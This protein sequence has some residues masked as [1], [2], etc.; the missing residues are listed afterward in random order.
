MTANIMV[1]E[2]E[3]AVQ[4]LIATNLL[5]AGHRVMR[6]DNAEEAQR[7]LLESLPDLAVV[8]WILPGQSGLSFLRGLRSKAPTRDM[9]LIMVTA[10]SS[11]HDKVTALESGADDYITKPFSPREMIARIYAVLRRRAPHAV[12][13]TL[14]LGKLRLDL[15]THRVTAGTRQVSLG[16]T[17]F[18]ML[19]FFMS[20]PGH[21]HSR[22]QLLDNIWG[23]SDLLEERTIDTYVGR[24]RSALKTAGCHGLIETLRGSGYRFLD[25]GSAGKR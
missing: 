10:R 15:V 25:P 14:E 19:R 7:M 5:L 17:E 9:P 3:P 2:D 1:V 16:P 8:D 18:R 6:A 20:H 21:V 4:E 12:S 23:S 24:L 13:D 22:A 11:E